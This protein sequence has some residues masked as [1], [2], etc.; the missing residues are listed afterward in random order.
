MGL[1]SAMARSWRF[2]TGH[3]PLNLARRR[4]RFSI[5]TCAPLFHGIERPFLLYLH[6]LLHD[7]GKS[8][9]HR[10]LS[11]V[12]G[13]MAM[14]V[15]KRLGLDGAA[16][17]TLRLVIENHLLM[18]SVSQRRDLD[19]PAGIRQFAPHVQNAETLALLTLH[20]FAHTLAT[21]DNLWNGFKDSLLWA[22][23]HKAMAM[24]TGGTEFMR[25]EE[26]Q[27]ELLMEEVHRLM[28]RAFEEDE[29]QAHFAMLPARYFQIHTARE[30]LDDLLLVHR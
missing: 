13:D 30:I 15:A 2:Q 8:D 9:G 6:L 18:A 29:L 19:D 24:L 10:N 26:K 22:L 17:H 28:A 16:T 7:V 11:V 3:F 20:T 4:A 14:R 25:A 5:P 23:Q 27:R 12:G 21:S 1:S